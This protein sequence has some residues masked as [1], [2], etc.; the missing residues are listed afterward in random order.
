M[1]IY[2]RSIYL[3][4]RDIFGRNKLIDNIL[5]QAKYEKEEVLGSNIEEENKQH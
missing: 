1:G 4:V 5:S 3:E 2:I